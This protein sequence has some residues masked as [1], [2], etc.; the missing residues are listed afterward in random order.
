[1]LASLLELLVADADPIL[2]PPPPDTPHA[3]LAHSRMCFETLARLYYLR[4]GFEATDAL[5]GHLLTALSFMFIGK[6]KT[7]ASSSTNSSLMEVNDVRATL[8]LAA[9]SLH[10]QGQNY[11]VCRTIYHTIESQVS[12]EDAELMSKFA[13]VR[14]EDS[15]A[16]QLR[17]SYLQSQFPVGVAKITDS[18]KKHLGDL[19]KEYADMAPESTSQ[20]E[21]SGGGSSP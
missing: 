1:M 5:A 20:A 7:L 3:A 14:K 12:S 6:L 9:K 15:K 8:I 19:V 13:H 18:P 17:A 4:H 21:S 10:D 16:R 11:Y 2:D